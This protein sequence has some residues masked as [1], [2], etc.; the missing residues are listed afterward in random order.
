MDDVRMMWEL[1]LERAAAPVGVSVLVAAGIALLVVAITP[2]WRVARYAVTLA[3][4][5][6]HAIVAVLAGR[7]LSG[8]RVHSDTSGLTI[9]RGRPRGLG[10]VLTFA[11]GYP[12]PA[13][14]GLAGVWLTAAGQ[15]VGVVVGLVVLLLLALVLVRNV[16]G[17]VVVLAV[18]AVLVAGLLLLPIGIGSALP[19]LLCLVLV[20][21]SVRSAIE[22][23]FTR[24]RHPGT[25][26]AD[27]LARLTHIPAVVWV[28]VFVVLTT[29]GAVAALAALLTT[30]ATA[31]AVTAAA[32]A[33]AVM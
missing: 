19:L 17:G 12:G 5:G 14:I 13:I 22:L 32:T 3:H 24:R 15:A 33:A 30:T 27:A 18:G 21:G 4:E 20:A 29:G 16:V 25:S 6:A 1:L 11:A 10:V 23:G 8:I 9:S 31:T 26:D 28:A 7:R 2:I